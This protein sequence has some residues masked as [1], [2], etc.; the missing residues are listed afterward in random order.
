M[1]A[2]AFWEAEGPHLDQ[3]VQLNLSLL[4]KQ[5]LKS[6]AWVPAAPGRSQGT[7]RML[8]VAKE[9]KRGRMEFYS[10]EQDASWTLPVLFYPVAGVNQPLWKRPESRSALIAFGTVCVRFR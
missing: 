10:F 4:C 1:S 7:G 8:K 2:F 9:A 6:R 5:K 3:E